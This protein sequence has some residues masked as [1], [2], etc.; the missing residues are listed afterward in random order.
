[1]V[2][3]ANSVHNPQN[4]DLVAS[5]QGG[6]QI[7]SCLVQDFLLAKSDCS[8]NITIRKFEFCMASYISHKT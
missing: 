6:S 5:Y 2:P 8:K 4:N 7:K 3:L 1:M